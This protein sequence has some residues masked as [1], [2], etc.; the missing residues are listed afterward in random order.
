MLWCGQAQLSLCCRKTPQPGRTVPSVGSGVWERAPR[1]PGPSHLGC[2]SSSEGIRSHELHVFQLPIVQLGCPTQE[3]QVRRQVGQLL[4]HRESQ[5]LTPLSPRGPLHCDRG[6][7]GAGGP[8]RC[9][10]ASHQSS[11]LDTLL[12]WQ[13]EQVGGWHSEEELTFLRASRT[14][15][16]R[17][18]TLCPAWTFMSIFSMLFSSWRTTWGRDGRGDTG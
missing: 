16:Y 2:S 3:V 13:G 14:S 15:R 18:V 5:H 11:P 1:C 7:R 8:G 6:W 12:P 4:G 17:A 9:G 10:R